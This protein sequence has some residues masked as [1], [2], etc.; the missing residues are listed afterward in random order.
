MGFLSGPAVFRERRQA[1]RQDA[2]QAVGRR[3]VEDMMGNA[4]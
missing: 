3:L 2:L 4:R 1:V